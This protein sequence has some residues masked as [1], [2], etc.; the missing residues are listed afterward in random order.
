MYLSQP[1]KIGFV[2]K[3]VATDE[4]RVVSEDFNSQGIDLLREKRAWLSFINFCKDTALE[5]VQSTD[6]PV[7]AW[8]K[9][10]QWYR[11]C[12]L[13]K[14]G[15]LMREFNSLKMILGEEPK[16]FTMRV[17]RVAMELRRVGNAVDEGD[18]NLAILNGLTQEYAVEQ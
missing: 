8:R 18:K 5:I 4:I 6:S 2:E 17:D 14:K 11:A 3:L 12:C 7:A 16:K 9:F 15:K 10:L 13:K 1:R